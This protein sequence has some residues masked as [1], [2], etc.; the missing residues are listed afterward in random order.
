MSIRFSRDLQVP[1]D[2]QNITYSKYMSFAILPEGNEENKRI[3]G[4]FESI[5]QY[6]STNVSMIDGDEVNKTRLL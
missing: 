3:E 1:F 6:N 5:H 2:H 4:D